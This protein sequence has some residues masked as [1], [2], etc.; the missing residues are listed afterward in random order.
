MHNI[1]LAVQNFIN[2]KNYYPNAGTWFENN[3]LTGA[4]LANP[5]NSAIYKALHAPSSLNLT[6]ATPPVLG[7]NVSSTGAPL[8][9]WVVDILPYIDQQALYNSWN[10]N[11]TYFDNVN[12]PANGGPTNYTIANNAI[13]ILRCPDDITAQPNQGNLSYVVNGGFSLWHTVP[14]AWTPFVSDGNPAVTSGG[15]YNQSVILN[16][17]AAGPAGAGAASKI[18]TTWPIWQGTAQKMG[19]M[20]QGTYNG[21]MPWD[22]K[23]NTASVYDG[24]AATL[25]LGENTLAGFAREG[26]TAETGSLPTSWASPWPQYTVFIASDDVCSFSGTPGDCYSSFPATSPPPPDQNSAWEWANSRSIPG[27]SFKFI[28]YG[29]H[30]LTIE[31]TSPFANSGHPGGCNFAFCDGH[32]AFL[33]DTIDGSVYAKLITPS[34]TRLPFN[35]GAAGFKQQPLGEDAFTQ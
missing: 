15:T 16:W 23:T 14:L 25:L 10:K 21:N 11:L 9:S 34:G 29:Q 26:F 17:N 22:V 35:A 7:P 31:G 19:V 8:Y 24:A 33:Q 4:Q 6:A 18:T 2:T 5:A 13:A 32:V 3:T 1:A 12:A 27:G 20:F 28:N 30:N